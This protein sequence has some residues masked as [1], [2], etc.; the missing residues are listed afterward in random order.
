MPHDQ[1]THTD[2]CHMINCTS[3]DAGINAAQATHSPCHLRV[4]K[5]GLQREYFRG[6][7][8][9]DNPFLSCERGQLHLQST[10]SSLENNAGCLCIM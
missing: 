3:K 4:G 10:Y 7:D 1:K 6:K 8:L 5:L 9:Q 2:S